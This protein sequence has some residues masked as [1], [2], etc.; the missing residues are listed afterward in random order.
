MHG[1][2]RA[3]HAASQERQHRGAAN[4]DPGQRGEAAEADGEVRG[5][6]IISTGSQTVTDQ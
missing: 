2:P 5:R 3:V 6:C 1:Q 4:E